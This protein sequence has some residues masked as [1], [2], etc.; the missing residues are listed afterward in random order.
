MNHVLTTV[1]F[2]IRFAQS[3]RAFH[4]T[5]RK[6]HL[7]N[8]GKYA[9]SIVVVHRVVERTEAPTWPE[10]SSFRG[11]PGVDRC[12]EEHAPTWPAAPTMPWSRWSP[13][14]RWNQRCR[15][16]ETSRGTTPKR[17]TESAVSATAC[18]DTL[19]CEE[20]IKNVREENIWPGPHEYATGVE[21]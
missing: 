10:R 12:A 15:V 11:A 18:Q 5:G 13:T 19:G 17:R 16:R 4:D 20:K 7:A 9:C 2:W 1:P 8:A 6:K 3:L 14:C 21:Y